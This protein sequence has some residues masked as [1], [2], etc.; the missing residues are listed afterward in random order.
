[1]SHLRARVGF[2][3]P[4][5]P[6]ILRHHIIV[7]VHEVL[8]MTAGVSE[9]MDTASKRTRNPRERSQDERSQT[10]PVTTVAGILDRHLLLALGFSGLVTKERVL[11]PSLPQATS[12]AEAAKGH[13]AIHRWGGGWW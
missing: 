9:R 1:M 13:K 8:L 5:C 11:P 3:L 6:Q 2:H 10:A 7:D 4:P 12:R